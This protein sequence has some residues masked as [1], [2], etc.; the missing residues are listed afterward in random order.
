MEKEIVLKAYA[1]VNLQLDVL[2]RR[3]D[4]YHEL[5]G[6]MQRIS[7]YDD[8]AICVKELSCS[9]GQDGDERLAVAF[10]EPVP[11]N[12]TVRRAA[13]LFM[14][15]APFAVAINVKKSIPSEAGLGG[16]S[17]DAAAVLH[18]L[19]CIFKGTD[20]ERSIGELRSI[21][22]SVGADVPFCLLGGCAEAKGVGEL[23]APL[24]AA[25]LSLLVVKGDRGVSTAR[26]FS[27]L[28]EQGGAFASC[29]HLPENALNDMKNAI[30][31]QDKAAIGRLMLNALQPAAERIAP[32]IADYVIRMRESGALG[33]CMT[34]SGAAVIG[35]FA[36]EAAALEAKTRFADCAFAEVCRS[37]G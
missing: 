28:D 11:Y 3:G 21:G 36:D 18:G 14:G 23:L 35:L 27:L 32:E 24:P 9:C 1:K 2:G 37:K 22:L 25:K 34:G 29:S 16:A 7:L 8:I 15:Q 5:A 30:I 4:G 31:I 10:N 12:N 13:E 20:L 17:A 19:N 6:V 26:L 33:A